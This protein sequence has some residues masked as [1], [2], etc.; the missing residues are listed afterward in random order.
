MSLVT[1]PRTRG[2]AD[3]RLFGVDRRLVQGA[4]L[5]LLLQL[6]GLIAESDHLYSHF[7]L[8]SDYALFV[9]AWTLIAHGHLDPASTIY[10]S[11][12]FLTNHFEL[13]LYPLALLW[14]V[15]PHGITLLVAQNVA[16]VLSEAVAFLWILDLLEERRTR[17]RR[18]G[19]LL[20]VV[21]LITIVLNPWIWWANAF[22]FH[23]QAF[24]TLFG[25]LAA[26]GFWS[27][28]GRPWVWVVLT[29][30]CGTVESIVLVGLGITLLLARRNLWPQGIGLMAAGTAWVVILSTLGFD[31][32]SQLTSQYGYLVRAK[33][34]T[35][36]SVFRLILALIEHGS[37]AVRVAGRRWDDLWHI[38]TG[39]GTLGVFTFIGMPMS[40]L[41]LA[42]SV[43]NFSPTVI[44][45]IASYQELPIFIFVPVGSFVAVTWLLVQSRRWVRVTGAVLGLAA[46]GQVLALSVVWTPRANAE[47]A[48]VAPSS[49][50]VLNEVLKA[51]SSDDEVVASNGVVGRFAERAWI[52]SYLGTEA[53][54]KTVPIRAKTVVFV[55]APNQGIE[56]APP[57]KTVASIHYV[58]FQ[59]RA[60][61]IASS[62]GIYAF[63]W[64]PPRGVRSITLPTVG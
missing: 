17:V 45:P 40:V 5:I 57:V 9:Q 20:A 11:A 25:V 43:L 16:T 15:Y 1:G 53:G 37:T 23:L 38:I 21:I 8:T 42:P 52:Y 2:D 19:E 64:H 12:P 47:F 4:G 22:D 39:S 14:F 61:P 51:T 10:R 35:T 48:R 32:G 29:L 27:G 56:T 28:R 24:A 13:I 55:L 59:L 36:V 3:S 44:S 50:Q 31:E 7:D 41:I 54:G 62:E 58:K 46:L 33:P 6:V 63:V 18:G 26:R 34:G 49:A 60:R 30:C